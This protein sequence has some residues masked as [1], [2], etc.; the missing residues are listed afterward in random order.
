MTAVTSPIML[1]GFKFNAK[2]CSNKSIGLTFHD[3]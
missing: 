3:L 2:L 1:S